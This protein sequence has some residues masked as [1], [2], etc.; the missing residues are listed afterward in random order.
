MTTYPSPVMW[1]FNIYG[2]DKTH[3]VVAKV[4]NACSVPL[5]WFYEKAAEISG[6]SLGRFLDVPSD[7]LTKTCAWEYPVGQR[8]GN[9]IY[10]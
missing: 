2:P 8:T 3:R 10:R 6:V 5:R 9:Y 4:P 7:R 1:T